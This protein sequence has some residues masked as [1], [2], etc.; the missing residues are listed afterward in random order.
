MKICTALLFLLLMAAPSLAQHQELSLGN[1]RFRAVKQVKPNDSGSKDTLIT[2]Y[3]L[4]TGKP[5]L[6]LS[7]ALYSYGADCNN[8]VTE[9]SS[10]HIEGD[11]LIFTTHISQKTGLDPIPCLQR[12]AYLPDGKGTLRKVYDGV[13]YESSGQW[14]PVK[15]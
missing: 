3:R 2:L 6:A 4:G 11:S 13:K 8:A 15:P 1:I 10:M 14:L 7:H 5:V 9:H 12:E